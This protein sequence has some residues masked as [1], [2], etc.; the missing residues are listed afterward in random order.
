MSNHVPDSHP[1]LL[2]GTRHWNTFQR[3]TGKFK[4]K[5]KFNGLHVSNLNCYAMTFKP[6]THRQQINTSLTVLLF[7]SFVTTNPTTQIAS[8]EQKVVNTYMEERLDHFARPIL[9]GWEINYYRR[10]TTTGENRLPQ[11]QNS[12]VWL[13]HC[14]SLPEKHTWSLAASPF[15]LLGS[16]EQPCGRRDRSRSR[17]VDGTLNYIDFTLV[18]WIWQKK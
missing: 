18:I 1:H 17:V 9:H 12:A 16:D 10:E 8:Q 3:E 15:W 6:K 5:F 11:E 7:P 14:S 2:Q 4:I 13:L